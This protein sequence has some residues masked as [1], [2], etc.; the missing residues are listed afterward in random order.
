MSNTQIK[1]FIATTVLSLTAVGGFAAFVIDH[2][3]PPRREVIQFER[4]VVVAKRADAASQLA[5]DPATPA[6]QA[7]HR[8]A[9]S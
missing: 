4:V 3:E 6:R 1:A 7:R 9:L 2:P 5:A 8:S